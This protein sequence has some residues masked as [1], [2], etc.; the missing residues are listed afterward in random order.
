MS[1]K[2][3]RDSFNASWATLVPTIPLLDIINNDPE[4]DTMPDLWASVE[5]TA[6][7]EL[8]ASLGAPSCRREE[9]TISVVLAAR[10]GTGDGALNDAAELV[11][12]AYRY[13]KE[14]DLATTQIDPPLSSSGFSD[15]YWYLMD[16]DITYN[17]D[18]FI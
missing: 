18:R 17:Y 1:S 8:P 16:I 4:H 3:V 2:F 10:S 7:N 13:W 12:D 15:G 9:G 11:R 6:F 5:F 14:G